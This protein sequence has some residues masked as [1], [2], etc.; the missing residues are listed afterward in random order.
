[1]TKSQSN[2]MHTDGDRAMEEWRFPLSRRRAL[3]VLAAASLAHVVP[4]RAAAALP[5]VV[6]NKD[7]GCGCCGAWVE[8]LR[9]AGFPVEIVETANVNAVKQRLGVPPDLTSCHTA[10]AQGYVVEG[11]VP[12]S[13]ILRLL[14]EKPQ[15]IGLAVPG[16]PI[17]SPG[18]ENGSPE[19]YEVVL[20]G[21]QGRR[22]FA[23][24]RGDREV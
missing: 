23:R 18:M 22:T 2:S 4:V 7:P 12:A 11:H 13:A 6:V 8:H 5:K 14:G 19:T 3:G 21:A 10:E 20:F 16:M 15:A 24:Y 9:S 1:M 17:G